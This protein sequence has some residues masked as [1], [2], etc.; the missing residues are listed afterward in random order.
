MKTPMGYVTVGKTDAR[1][2][3]NLL[4]TQTTTPR[5]RLIS[6]LPRYVG[7]LWLTL[8]MRSCDR[9]SGPR[10][11]APALDRE[12]PSNGRSSA[13]ESDWSPPAAAVGATR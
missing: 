7:N 2:M 1:W 10:R 4:M 8:R 3:K 13:L 5:A 6:I 11:R 9:P 12:R